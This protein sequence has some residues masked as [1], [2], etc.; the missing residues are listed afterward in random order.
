MD[1]IIDHKS[2][3]SAVSKDDG[4]EVTKSGQQRPENTTKGWLLSFGYLERRRFIGMGSVERL[5]EKE[6]Y[7]IETAEYAIANKIVEEPAFAWWAR[8]QGSEEAQPHY[9]HEGQVL[10][11]LQADS[12]KYGIELP[13]SVKEALHIDSETGTS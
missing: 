7:P 5:L 10:L 2:N 12:H 11:L 4:F 9:Q 13:K 1:A 6:S 3:G 8:P